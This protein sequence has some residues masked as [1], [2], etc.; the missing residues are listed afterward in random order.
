MTEVPTVCLSHMTEAEKRA[1]VIA[2]NRLAEEAGWDRSLLAV[3]F[4]TLFE[5]APELDLTIT[6]F[7]FGEIEF[8]HVF[9]PVSLLMPDQ[10]FLNVRERTHRGGPGGAP[11]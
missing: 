6:G 3:E 11:D 2:H 7:E 10:A 8:I 5:I 9:E 4:K 1:F